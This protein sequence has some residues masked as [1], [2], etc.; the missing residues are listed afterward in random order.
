MVEP[1]TNRMR[2]LALKAAQELD[3]GVAP[4]GHKFLA[5]NDITLDEAYDLA[6]RLA[7]G[8]R[9]SEALLADPHGRAIWGMYAGMALAATP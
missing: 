8:I 5:E 2:Q 7:A 9:V 1:M 3:E 6:E 4:L